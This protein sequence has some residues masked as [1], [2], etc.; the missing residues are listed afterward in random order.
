MGPGEGGLSFTLAYKLT[1]PIV[2]KVQIFKVRLCGSLAA[3]A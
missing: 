3:L 2:G 1:E